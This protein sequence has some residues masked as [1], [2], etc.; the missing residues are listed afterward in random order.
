MEIGESHLGTA[1]VLHPKGRVDGST[2]A[3][4]QARL[5]EAVTAAAGGVIVDFTDVDYI[6]SA[7]LRAL[8]TAIRQRKDRRLAAAALRPV[9]QEI[10]TIARFQHVVPIFASAEAAANSWDAGSGA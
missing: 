9:L 6:S 10:F 7:G 5:L 8:M 1:V 2:S 3:E 4:F